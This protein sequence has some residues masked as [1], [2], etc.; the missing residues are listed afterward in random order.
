MKT[1]LL[2][3][4][5][6]LLSFGLINLVSYF[7]ISFTVAIQNRPFPFEHVYNV[8]RDEKGTSYQVGYLPMEEAINHPYWL[9]WSITLYAGIGTIIFAIWRQNK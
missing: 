6:A 5:I 8:V 9:V 2:I 1:R 4:G 7:P 3:I